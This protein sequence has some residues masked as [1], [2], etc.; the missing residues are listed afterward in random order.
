ML[1]WYGRPV[2]AVSVDQIIAGIIEAE[3]REYSDNPDDAGGPTKFG[4]T[5]A[6]LSAWRGH[7]VSADDV[8]ALSE[9]EARA[10]YRA[11]YVQSPGFDAV[12]AIAPSIGAELVDTGVNMGPEASTKFLQRALNVLNQE[13]RAYPD[14]AV[15]GKC[16]HATIA[17]LRAFISMRGLEGQRVLLLAL[18]CLQG[19]RYIELSE[20]RQQNESFV[21]GWLKNRVAL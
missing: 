8:R 4:I 17:A 5:Q 13:G 2:M 7:A 21:Y 16:G 18:N 12:L 15:D 1:R 3:G 6:V 20:Q 14:I 11:R 10:I 9:D 19:A